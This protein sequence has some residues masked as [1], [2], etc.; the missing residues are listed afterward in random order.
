MVPEANVAVAML[1][2]PESHTTPALLLTV[3]AEL[4]SNLIPNDW[5][6]T[7]PPPAPMAMR[8]V[9]NIAVANNIGTGRARRSARAA[10]GLT[11]DGAHGVT[12]PTLALINDSANVIMIRHSK[13]LKRHWMD[14]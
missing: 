11:H 6:C 13:H 14:A 7:F 9:T 10:L 5:A 4:P 12:R 8:T 2:Q 1:L 3:A